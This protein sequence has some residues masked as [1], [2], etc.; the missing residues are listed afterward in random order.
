MVILV[1]CT[2][3]EVARRPFV[4]EG[5]EE[6]EMGSQVDLAIREHPEQRARAP[7]C[8]AQ[9]K[10]ALGARHE[11]LPPHRGQLGQPNSLANEEVTGWK[12]RTRDERGEIRATHPETKQRPGEGSGGGSENH[13]RFA[14][15]PTEIDL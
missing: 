13:V 7:R 14:G 15:I 2:D 4:T 8:A 5:I 6:V 3:S 11:M 9:P 12:R 1:D 10:D